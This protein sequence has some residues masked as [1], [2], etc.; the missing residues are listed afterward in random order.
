MQVQLTVKKDWE[1]YTRKMQDRGIQSVLQLK[2]S[3]PKSSKMPGTPDNW[4]LSWSE[5]FRES[6]S[7]RL[8]THVRKMVKENLPYFV[9]RSWARSALLGSR[10][11]WSRKSPGAA[12]TSPP[13]QPPLIST[14]NQACGLQVWPKRQKGSWGGNAGQAMST[15]WCITFKYSDIWFGTSFALHKWSVR[16]GVLFSFSV[17]DPRCLF[18]HASKLT[19]NWGLLTADLAAW[20][21][22]PCILPLT[23][24]PLPSFLYNRA[25]LSPLHL[26]LLILLYC[27]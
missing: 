13:D 7:S 6:F 12:S 22:L 9:T 14:S 26:L 25:N 2:P 21:A 16:L 17:H 15:G 4:C 11:L 18:L 5:V 23:P 24:P 27:L 1:W 3:V 10:W 19:P 20:E 8:E